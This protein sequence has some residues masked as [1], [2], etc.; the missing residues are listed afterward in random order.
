MGYRKVPTIH[1]LE[2]EQYEGL[3]VR[4]K[5]LKIGKIRK[6]LTVLDD[7]K[8]SVSATMDEMVRIIVEGLVSWN[9]EDEHGN[10]L[11]TTIEG[12]EE[13]EFDELSAILEEWLGKM[14]GPDD[15]LG[16]GS[17]SGVNFPGQPLTMEAL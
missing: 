15:D 2:F 11:P 16:K 9:R 13:L 10:E 17:P 7:D 8:R 1:T 14:T 6:V 3:V 5:G 4:M 12:V